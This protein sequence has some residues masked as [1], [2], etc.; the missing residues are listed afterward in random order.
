MTL[1]IDLSPEVEAWLR[2]EA[3]SQGQSVEDYA[4]EE[5]S[6]W[7]RRTL[8]QPNADDLEPTLTHTS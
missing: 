4:S 3:T 5:F 8:R 1:T 7:L 2:E 6:A